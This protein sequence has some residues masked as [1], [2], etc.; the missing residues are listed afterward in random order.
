MYL[1][2]FA[3]FGLTSMLCGLSLGL[4]WLIAFRVLQ[5]ASG[6]MLGANSVDSL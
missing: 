5:G 3:L 1:I 6:A 2:G 4:P